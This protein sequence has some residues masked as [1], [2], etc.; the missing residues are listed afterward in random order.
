[1]KKEKFEKILN[2]IEK[3]LETKW[4]HIM[5]IIVGIVF[6]MLGAFHTTVWF[7]EAYTIGLIRHNYSDII[8][9]DSGDVHPV[10]YYLILKTVTL[11]FGDS[12]LVCR[13]FS[14]LAGALMGVI[15]YT[16]IR[17]DFGAKVGVAFSFLTLF[18]PFMPL[19]A[20][21]IRMYTWVMLFATL[22]GIYAYRICKNSKVINWVLFAIFS[23]C[24]AHTHYYGLVTVGII[25]AMLFF[26]IIFSKKLYAEQEKSKKSYLIRF[27][28]TA[29]VQIMGYV[30]W[31]YVL[32]RQVKLVNSYYWIEFSFGESILAPLGAQ[33]YGRLSYVFTFVFAVIMYAYLI[34]QIVRAKKQKQN[35][36]V[37][38]ACLLVHFIVFI[39]MLI[40]SI[41]IKPIM[42]FRYMLVTTGFFILPFA[43]CIAKFN[44]TKRQKII[45]AIIVLIILGVSIYNNAEVVINNYNSIN[46]Q[47]VKYIEDNYEEG[48]II[49]YKDY[50]KGIDIG[51][52]LPEYNWYYYYIDPNHDA[53]GFETFC[54][55]LKVTFDEDFFDDYKGKIIIVDNDG[56]ELYNELSEKYEL[57][58]IK[59]N[60]FPTTY[61]DRTYNIIVVEK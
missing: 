54:P 61:K 41:L 58:E 55:P 59:R 44:Q 1:M 4:F 50:F 47:E 42:Y 32:L 26:Y 57:K 22:A 33:F 14:V 23:L 17:K 39:S 15:G 51:I 12:I 60:R 35:L 49:V 37:I 25:N 21:E 8:R 34:Y 28:I 11:I 53:S 6:I 7:D 27:G 24:A 46:G 43:I 56:L 9:I 13:L 30:P 3:I 16:H 48:D 29:I 19:Y 36:G 31:L 40:V 52:H 38:W 18:L 5:L 20:I 2:K 10:L 45:T